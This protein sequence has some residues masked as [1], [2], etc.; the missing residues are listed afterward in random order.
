VLVRAPEAGRLAS[1]LAG[2][3][4]TITQT[5]ADSLEIAGLSAAEI[6][7]VA[8]EERIVLHGLTPQEAS[9]EEAFMEMT[10]DAVDFHARTS[11]E[12]AA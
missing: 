1:A 11:S 7:Q 8:L 10:R 12:A 5:G 9:L 3:G 2:D 6:G 4:V